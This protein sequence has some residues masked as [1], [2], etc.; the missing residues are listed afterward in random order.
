MP[1]FGLILRQISMYI[2][3]KVNLRMH[4][5]EVSITCKMVDKGEINNFS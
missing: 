5:D 4:C 3:A 2:C 1:Y